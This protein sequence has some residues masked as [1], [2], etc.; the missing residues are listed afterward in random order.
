MDTKRIE[1]E[2][3]QEEGGPIYS[4]KDAVILGKEKLGTGNCQGRWGRPK[5]RK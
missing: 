4:K 1:K 5:R 2:E 3:D